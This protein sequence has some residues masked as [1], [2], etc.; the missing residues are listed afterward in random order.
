MKEEISTTLHRFRGLSF[1]VFRFSFSLH[2]KMEKENLTLFPISSRILLVEFKTMYIL[3]FAKYLILRQFPIDKIWRYSL[4][5]LIFSFIFRFGESIKLTRFDKWNDRQ[6]YTIL[7]S[8]G[9][10]NSN[11]VQNKENAI[12]FTQL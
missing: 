11:F 12:E 6:N 8:C 4:I 3:Y 1:F 9:E 10:T 2:S 5:S 7:S